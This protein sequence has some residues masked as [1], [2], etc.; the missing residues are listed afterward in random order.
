[1]VPC[2]GGH[3]AWQTEMICIKPAHDSHDPNI[4]DRTIRQVRAV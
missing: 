4:L 2:V 1:M 3:I